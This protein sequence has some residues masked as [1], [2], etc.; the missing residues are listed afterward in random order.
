MTDTSRRMRDSD[1]AQRTLICAFKGKGFVAE[2]NGEDLEIFLVSSG[3]IS[4][5]V[6]GDCAVGMTAGKLQK[7]IEQRRAADADAEARATIINA[8][9]R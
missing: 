9:R 1:L 4:T 2:R 6:I 8:A 5:Q 3:S 7:V